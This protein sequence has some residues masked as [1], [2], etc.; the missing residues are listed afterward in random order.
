MTTAD[1]GKR[2][3]TVRV[4]W[5]LLFWLTLWPLLLYLGITL[6]LSIE[7]IYAR[8]SLIA[9]SFLGVYALLKTLSAY[10]PPE[11]AEDRLKQIALFSVVLLACF[12]IVDVGEAAYVNLH[13]NGGGSD[14]T[15]LRASDSHT[16]AGELMPQEYFPTEANFYLYKPD[17][18]SA[19]YAYGEFYSPDLL[20]HQIVRDEVLKLGHVEFSID[21]YGLRNTQRP[22]DSRIFALGDSFCFGNHMTQDATWTSLLEATLGEPVYNMGVS[23]TSPFQQLQILQYLILEYP[24]SFRPKRLLWMLFEGNDLEDSYAPKRPEPGLF[25]KAF[26]ETLVEEIGLIPRRLRAESVMRR[27]VDGKLTVGSHPEQGQRSDHYLL[28]GSRL[29]YPLYYSPRFGHILFQ[30]NYL[31]RAGKPLSYVLNHPNRKRL[32]NTFHQMREI[33]QQQGFEVTVVVVPGSIRLYKDDFEDLPP[34]SA[35]PYFINYLRQLSMESGFETMDL[36]ALLA[37]YA[38]TELLYQRDDTHWNERGHEIVA[39]LIHDS[40]FQELPL[41]AHSAAAK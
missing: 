22:E 35:E 5:L 29:S 32:E 34:V 18:L 16:W 7:G 31:D 19:G 6:A 17:A 9:V 8:A 41:A 2:S 15:A 24:K 38:R 23:G 37:P 21:Q 25:T 13:A 4:R 20:R 28:D 12:L 11:R 36:N 30:Q 39:G 1:R 33:S 14:I 27:L 26:H 3:R 40:V 10:G